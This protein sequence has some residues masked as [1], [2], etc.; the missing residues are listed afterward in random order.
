MC[1]SRVLARAELRQFPVWAISRSHRI[2][3]GLPRQ[4]SA[5]TETDHQ[6]P[7]SGWQQVECL[8][9]F[10]LLSQGLKGLGL[11]AVAD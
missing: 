8:S 3:R 9:V 7:G 10:L 1:I 11:R 6:I 4:A 5:F 2:R